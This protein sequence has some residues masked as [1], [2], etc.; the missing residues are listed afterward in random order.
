[1]EKGR[2][3]RNMGADE[4]APRIDYD[5][6]QKERADKTRL[7][8][9]EP[10]HPLYTFARENEAL[11]ELLEQAKEAADEGK[12]SRQLLE[13]V[14]GLAIHYAKKGDLLYPHLKVHYQISGPSDVM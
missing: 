11:S 6:I 7:L 5:R 12:V 9:E 14:R 4:S 13:A 3:E 1:M 10:G 8:T 2:K